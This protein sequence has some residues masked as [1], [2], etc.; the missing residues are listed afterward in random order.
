MVQFFMSELAE[1]EGTGLTASLV[2]K[3]RM[4]RTLAQTTDIKLGVCN[5]PFPPVMIYFLKILHISPNRHQIGAK[6]LNSGSG[7]MSHSKHKT[8]PR[9]KHGI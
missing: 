5:D 8:I 2:R 9:C 6:C 7:N 3:Q 4:D 1:C